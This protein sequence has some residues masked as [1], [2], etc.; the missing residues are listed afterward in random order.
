[1]VPNKTLFC[2]Y[3]NDTNACISATSLETGLVQM[4]Y[5]GE[6]CRQ[7]V[8]VQDSYLVGADE[9][10]CKLLV[11]VLNKKDPIHTIACPSRVRALSASETYIVAGIEN[12]IYIWM[13]G[14]GALL[15]TVDHHIQAVT[16]LQL[17]DNLLLASADEEGTVA[18]WSVQ[19]L[20]QR[21]LNHEPI[22][23]SNDHQGRV[24]HLCLRRSG[25]DQFV[26]ASAS[27]DRSVKVWQGAQM[28]LMH[29]HDH[30]HPATS[31]SINHN[32]LTVAYEDGSLRTSNI[33]ED[34]TRDFAPVSIPHT[35]GIRCIEVMVEGV[36]LVGM[37]N[38]QVAISY[39]NQ[40][41]HKF[42]KHPGRVTCMVVGEELG[43][44]WSESSWKPPMPFHP[45]RSQPDPVLKELN[46]VLR[47]YH[48]RSS[49]CGNDDEV[50]AKKVCVEVKDKC[51][52]K[53]LSIS[54]RIIIVNQ[55]IDNLYKNNL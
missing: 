48:N 31:V 13:I 27:Q 8:L 37:W 21:S 20:L 6:A 53:N 36:V 4:T 16:S 42:L 10:R 30:N 5:R 46:L 55:F 22:C 26:V 40:P 29:S 11:W 52:K 45:L 7:L 35:S 51:N 3:A 12:I 28:K 38:G 32:L 33:I 17:C 49:P 41:P 2:S 19:G 15:R 47:S 43:E 23:R 39:L 44:G 34:Q 14:T 18:V 50:L 24:N 9:V 54:K 1:M 25:C